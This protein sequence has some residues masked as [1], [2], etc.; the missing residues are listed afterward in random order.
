VR[1]IA[2]DTGPLVAYFSAR[3]SH[4]DW[5]VEQLGL[6]APPLLTCEAVLAEAAYLLRPEGHRV[7][8]LLERGL[9]VVAFALEQESK[10]VRGLMR[11]YRGRSP[12]DLADACLVRMAELD[13]A[14]AVLTVD[15]EFR[16]VYR[17]NGRQAIDTLVP[18]ER[19]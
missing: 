13:P 3:D 18:P 6:V 7:L 1:R 14:V 2:T 16:N 5:A 15:R 10:A 8:E 12:M 11:R 4:H 17:K 19:R 9:L